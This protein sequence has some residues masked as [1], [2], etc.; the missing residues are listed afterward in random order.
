[1]RKVVTALPSLERPDAFL[2][3]RMDGADKESVFRRKCSKRFFVLVSF[4]KK[5]GIFDREEA[6]FAS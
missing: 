1:M 5:D 3:L 4:H 2:T 6:L